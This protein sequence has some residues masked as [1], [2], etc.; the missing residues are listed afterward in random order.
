M[1]KT[2]GNYLTAEKLHFGYTE[3]DDLLHN[4]SF[5]IKEGEC[6]GILGRSGAGK[7]TLMQLIAG[8]LQPA[9]G[10][11]RLDGEA[12]K[13]PEEQLIPG[14]PDIRLVA[15]DFDLKQFVDAQKNLGSA[16]S[17]LSD[18]QREKRAKSL[19]R[20]LYLHLDEKQRSH[21][22]SGG[23]KQRL[24]LGRAVAAKPS[25]LLLDEPFSN[26]DFRLKHKLMN[27]LQHEWKSRYILL[28]A[29][30]PADVLRLCDHVLVLQ[31]GKVVQQGPTEK[32]FYAPKNRY[33]AELL[34]PINVLSNET[35]NALGL[36]LLNPRRKTQF[37][38]PAVLALNNTGLAVE[39][40]QSH[41][42]G[43]C[44]EVT[45]KLKKSG[46]VLTVY[47]LKEVGGGECKILTCK[48]Y[49]C[50]ED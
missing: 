29:H 32:V 2:E 15:Q 47:S 12:I 39:I 40:V 11:L 16:L 5:N 33:V 37:V 21:E 25:V 45:A 38:R 35:C 27:H 3:S 30:D 44:F 19:G 28:S 49:D 26:L 22:V 7:T 6:W 42:N 1:K 41:F 10:S 18:A 20:K 31:K 46:E 48:E 50:S 14:H 8:N 17:H 4:I 23:Q 36:P 43:K 9:A 24:A 34:G 13:G